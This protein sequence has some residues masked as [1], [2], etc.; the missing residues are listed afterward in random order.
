MIQKGERNHG[1]VVHTESVRREETR[2][3][4]E[5]VYLFCRP[6][7]GI[8][9]SVKR[10]GDGA[11]WECQKQMSGWWRQHMSRGMGES[12]SVRGCLSNSE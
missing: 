2:K 4:R 7:E 9:H 1:W 6:G 3:A 12:S 10:N 11:G 8:R 5:H